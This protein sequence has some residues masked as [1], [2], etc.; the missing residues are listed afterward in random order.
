MIYYLLCQLNEYISIISFL[1]ITNSN[2]IVGCPV[3]QNFQDGG[4]D[5]SGTCINGNKPYKDLKEAWKECGKKVGCSKILKVTDP[6]GEQEFF[7]RREADKNKTYARHQFVKYECPGKTS[8]YSCKSDIHLKMYI[9]KSYINTAN[10]L[11]SQF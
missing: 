8:I 4:L 3:R 2:S 11:L 6:Y 1:N 7:L 5:C 9:F 10:Q